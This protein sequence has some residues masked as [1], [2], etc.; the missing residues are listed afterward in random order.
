MTTQAPVFGLID[1]LRSYASGNE[2]TPIKL[3]NDS[4]EPIF[5][6]RHGGQSSYLFQVLKI[7]E[8]FHASEI[9]EWYMKHFSTIISND[10]E[11][12]ELVKDKDCK[13]LLGLYS[14]DCLKGHPV[15][16]LFE[17]S[18]LVK[19]FNDNGI[20]AV[21][22]LDMPETLEGVRKVASM[23]LDVANVKDMSSDVLDGRLGEI[24]RTTF[25]RWPIALAWP[26]IVTIAGVRMPPE[27][28]S[29]TNL[30]CGLIGPMG[31]GKSTAV[32]RACVV[33]GL[34]QFIK[35]RLVAT[36]PALVTKKVGSGE[37]LAVLIGDVGDAP[38]LYFPGEL[39]HLLKKSNIEGASFTTILNDAYYNNKQGLVIARQKSVEFS[40]QLSLIGGMPEKDFGELFGAA[41][42]TGFYDRFIFGQNPTGAMVDFRPG[43]N[44]EPEELNPVSVTVSPDV[45]ELRNEWT[46]TKGIGPRIAEHAVTVA[47]ICAAFDRRNVLTAADLGPA[48]AFAQY[49]QGLR[50]ALKPNEGEN[51]SGKL[52]LMFMDY[53]KRNDGDDGSPKWTAVQDLFNN[54][55]AYRKGA[56]LADNVLRALERNGEVETAKLDVSGT[57]RKKAVVRRVLRHRT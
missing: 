11:I 57:G 2:P 50:T 9:G 24:Y 36:D 1:A 41:A 53:L 7:H 37:G 34:G 56:D 15:V 5:I 25:H 21:E 29:R 4:K 19:L 22:T 38:R 54:T 30:Y 44:V 20:S 18:K 35:D 32:D 26:T 17:N 27:N 43:E 13:K 40:C 52:S 42:S 8:R 14:R 12:N 6:C 23:F 47:T 45:W 16:M 3:P 10:E 28:P 46:K 33:F 51:F 49:Q 39:E 55:G 48:Y 31:C